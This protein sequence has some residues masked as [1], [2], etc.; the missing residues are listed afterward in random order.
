MRS[1]TEIKNLILNFA[2]QDDRI[3]AVLLNGSRANPNI[4]TDALQDFDI[5]FVADNLE[6]FTIDHSWINIFGEKI[7]SQLPDEMA[8]G[9]KNFLKK[10]ASL[11]GCYL[12]IQTG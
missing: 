7:I 3:R 10:Q 8:F 1:E 12:K 6:S 9:D 4:K 5:V 11:I 2:K